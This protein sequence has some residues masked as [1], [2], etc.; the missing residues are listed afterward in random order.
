[1][2]QIGLQSWRRFQTLSRQKIKEIFFKCN[3][4]LSGA[5]NM[6]KFLKN[7]PVN[8]A[9]PSGGPHSRN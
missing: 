1:M 3:D 2:L 4:F 6:T 5:K 8:V 7:F 9:F